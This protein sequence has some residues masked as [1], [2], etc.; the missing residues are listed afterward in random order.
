MKIVPSYQLKIRYSVYITKGRLH[1]ME[2]KGQC[3]SIVPVLLDWHG[4]GFFAAAGFM[5]SICVLL[6]VYSSAETAQSK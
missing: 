5:S 4:H 3:V 2:V 1:L 6:H